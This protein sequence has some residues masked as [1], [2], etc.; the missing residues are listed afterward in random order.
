MKKI[1]SIALVALL[2]VAFTSCK[3]EYTCTCS[4]DIAGVKGSTDV[5]SG[6]KLSKKDAKTW[7]EGYKTTG[8]SGVTCSLK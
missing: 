8:W 5:K 2:A 1:T 4:Y 3:K 6:T 7:C